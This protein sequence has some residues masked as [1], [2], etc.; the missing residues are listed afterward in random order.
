MFETALM[1]QNPSEP[2]LDEKGQSA[3][4][5]R[6]RQQKRSSQSAGA[7]SPMLASEGLDSRLLGRQ[8]EEPGKEDK[9][10]AKD[11]TGKE[12]E[13]GA[14][15]GKKGG[16]IE[17]LLNRFKSADRKKTLQAIGQKKPSPIDKFK[18]SEAR[19]LVRF[20]LGALTG[21]GLIGTWLYSNFH[22]F[23]YLVLGPSKIC[24]FGEEWVIGNPA[25]AKITG[26]TGSTGV[27]DVIKDKTMMAGKVELG[28]LL[29]IDA[30]VAIVLLIV[31]A[32]V[33]AL[34]GGIWGWLIKIYGIWQ[35]VKAVVPGI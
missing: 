35:D 24:R 27:E 23:L 32:V 1:G 14:R 15:K 17:G 10:G 16:G 11:K 29:F 31:A 22:L 13:A 28:L 4:D 21:V 18:Q 30:I 8:K 9:K 26:I 33:V 3:A 2:K 5:S 34:T 20:W 7:F 6:L 25:A 19:I 12:Q